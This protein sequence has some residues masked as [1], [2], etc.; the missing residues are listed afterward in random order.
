MRFALLMLKALDTV[1]LPW[2]TRLCNAA[3]RSE[4]LP[5]EWWTRVVV[6]I[7]KNGGWWVFSNYLCFVDLGKAYVQVPQWVF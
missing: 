4:T 3:W 6:A 2:L 7:F 1:G 5:V